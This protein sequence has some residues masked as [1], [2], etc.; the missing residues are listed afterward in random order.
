MRNPLR[1]APGQQGKTSQPGDDQ[2]AQTD[3]QR[4]QRTAARWDVLPCCPW[5]NQW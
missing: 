2:S 4:I 3:A 1:I 5:N